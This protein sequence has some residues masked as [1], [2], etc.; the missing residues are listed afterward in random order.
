MLIS[1]LGL[2]ASYVGTDKVGTKSYVVRYALTN[3]RLSTLS[4]SSGELE[5]VDPAGLV[6]AKGHLRRPITL[7]T[8]ESTI[9]EVDLSLSDA[10]SVLVG[11]YSRDARMTFRGYVDYNTGWLSWLFGAG[12]LE[13]EEKIPMQTILDYLGLYNFE[14]GHSDL[15]VVECIVDGG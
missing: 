10:L 6:V 12:R 4:I 14:T 3:G 9:L 11:R 7:G 15:V 8:G 5:V 2:S 1:M 13:F